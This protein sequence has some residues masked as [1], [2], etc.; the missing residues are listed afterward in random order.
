MSN[1]HSKNVFHI[2]I[3]CK[4]LQEATEFYVGKLGC[5]LARQYDD[6]IT[7]NF[8]GIQLVCHLDPQAIDLHPRMYPRHF[9]ITFHT[10]EEFEM[11]LAQAQTKKLP[12]FQEKIVR[13]KGLREEHYTF[14]L[15][16][17][18]NNLIEFKYYQDPEMMY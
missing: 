18:S 1:N 5:H 15:Q 13:F 9:G 7:L 3:P 14:F 12:F 16:D 4:D 11:L 6:R 2:A 10:K 8:L 17:P